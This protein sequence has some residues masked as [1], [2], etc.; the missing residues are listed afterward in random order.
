MIKIIKYTLF[1]AIFLLSACYYDNEENLN[2]EVNQACDLNNVTY[3]ATVKPILQASCYMCHSN[4][5]AASSGNGIKLENY[6]DVQ[7]MAKNGKLLGAVKHQSGYKP[8]PLGGVKLNDCDINK[9]EKW[10]LNG[11]LNN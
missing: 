1:L 6:T 3:T 10:V 5:N 2:P 7:N 9:L 4:T 11:T 8:M